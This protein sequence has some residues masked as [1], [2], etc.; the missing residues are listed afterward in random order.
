[1]SV[2]Y[3]LTAMAGI[4]NDKGERQAQRGCT[5]PA[6]MTIADE[7]NNRVSK[8]PSQRHAWLPREPRTFRA[9]KAV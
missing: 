4:E 1:M 9:W 2:A 8:K 7:G 6:T 5:L 3:A